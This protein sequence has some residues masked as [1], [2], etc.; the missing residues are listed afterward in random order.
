MASAVAKYVKT[1][2]SF[3]MRYAKLETENM[4][5]MQKLLHNTMDKNRAIDD[6][7]KGITGDDA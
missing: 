4:Q 5:A 1:D 6:L 2:P 7:G 3:Q